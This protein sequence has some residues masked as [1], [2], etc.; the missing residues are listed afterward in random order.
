M[1]T[2]NDLS[3]FDFL[4]SEPLRVI[5]ISGSRVGKSFQKK[6][7]NYEQHDNESNR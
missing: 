7:K 2:N 4:N 6:V 5:S 3:E 1:K